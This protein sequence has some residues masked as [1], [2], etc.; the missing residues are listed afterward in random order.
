M[1]LQVDS[2]DTIIFGIVLPWLDLL[3]PLRLKFG[4]GTGKLITKVFVRGV[5]GRLFLLTAL[6]VDEFQ[7]VG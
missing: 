1:Y 7:T 6:E 2:E 5:I 4:R 3:G